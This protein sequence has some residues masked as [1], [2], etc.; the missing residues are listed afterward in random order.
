MEWKNHKVNNI[1]FWFNEQHSLLA[2]DIVIRKV[3]SL[4]NY[5]D[6]VRRFIEIF[7]SRKSFISSTDLELG[8]FNDLLNSNTY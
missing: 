3:Y 1:D 4:E 2:D 7:I 8:N 5:L 6:L